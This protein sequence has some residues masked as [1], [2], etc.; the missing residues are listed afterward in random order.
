MGL[1]TEVL[2][3]WEAC[4]RTDTLFV[5]VCS[6]FCTYIF[7]NC[8]LHWLTLLGLGNCSSCRY[9]LLKLYHTVQFPSSNHACHLISNRL[10]DTVV[11]HWVY[12][13]I[14]RRRSDLRRLQACIPQERPRRACWNNSCSV[15]QLLPIGLSSYC[16]CHCGRRCL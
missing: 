7:P 4:D 10:H 2:Q 11:P 3:A 12:L 8:L 15:V 13:D 1:P 16:M 6:V 9:S 5:L 14:W